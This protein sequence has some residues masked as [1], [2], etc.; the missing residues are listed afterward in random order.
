MAQWSATPQIPTRLGYGP[1]SKGYATEQ[2]L[3]ITPYSVFPPAT[4]IADILQSKPM[5]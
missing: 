1:V 4:A 5:Q 2:G 3:Q